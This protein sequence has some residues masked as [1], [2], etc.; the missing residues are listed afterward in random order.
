MIKLKEILTEAEVSRELWY[1]I[2]HNIS[3]EEWE[4]T[5]EDLFGGFE[6]IENSDEEERSMDSE[7][8][9]DEDYTEEGYLKDGF[10]VP[11]NELLDDIDMV[12]YEEDELDDDENSELDEEEYLY[13]DE[14]L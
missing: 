10:V 2:N 11:D 8:Y 9:E 12:E 5:Y 6:D 13:S 7:V 14:E 4:K 3:L 1:H